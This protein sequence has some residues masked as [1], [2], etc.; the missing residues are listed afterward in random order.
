MSSVTFFDDSCRPKPLNVCEGI[1]YSPIFSNS[2]TSNAW[3]NFYES[4]QRAAKS[5]RVLGNL[6]SCRDK[7]K[8]RSSIGEISFNV[9]YDDQTEK[10]FIRANYKFQGRTEYVIV[11]VT[12]SDEL[13]SINSNILG[14]HIQ[15][16]SLNNKV[17]VRRNINLLATRLSRYNHI[18]RSAL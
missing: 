14:I 8:T 2:L 4:L 6:N 11:T 18:S 9:Y 5:N 3:R 16:I 17:V 13:L 15:Q 10:G 12:F 1:A 7:K